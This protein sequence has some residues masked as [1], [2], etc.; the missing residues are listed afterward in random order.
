[1]LPSAKGQ[2]TRLLYTHYKSFFLL[3]TLPYKTFLLEKALD[4]KPT[5]EKTRWNWPTNRKCL[6]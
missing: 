4:A 2:N 3:P 6:V 1:M 5:A